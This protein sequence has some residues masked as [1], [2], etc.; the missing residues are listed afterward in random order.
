M[1]RIP[2]NWRSLKTGN[3][4]P[5]DEYVNHG[6]GGIHRGKKD[7]PKDE[8]PYTVDFEII[9]DPEWMKQAIKRWRESK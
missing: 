2:R 9:D 3:T 6:Y 1:K 5:Y 7:L 8:Y 4:F